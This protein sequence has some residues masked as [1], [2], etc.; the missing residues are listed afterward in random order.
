MIATSSD[1]EWRFLN[2][3]R[4]PNRK[5]SSKTGKPK[6]FVTTLDEQGLQLYVSLRY[7]SAFCVVVVGKG[8]TRNLI[9]SAMI[10]VKVFS[11][12]KTHNETTLCLIC[13]S[14]HLATTSFPHTLWN[15]V[16]H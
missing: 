3:L 14:V 2:V 5:V 6:L 7:G 9:L 12:E 15:T 11:F 16:A 13:M 10:C 4:K 1:A 8:H